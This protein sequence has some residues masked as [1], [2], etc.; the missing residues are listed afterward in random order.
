[1]PAEYKLVL[2]VINYVATNVLI[3]QVFFAQGHPFQ[4]FSKSGLTKLYSQVQNRTKG[5]LITD[6]VVVG[7]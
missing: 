1:M 2:S 5:L 6:G 7:K 4:D 3:L